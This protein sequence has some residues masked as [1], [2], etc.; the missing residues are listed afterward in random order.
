MSIV[1]LVRV[2]LCGLLEEKDA[3][4]RELQDLGVAHLLGAAD[5]AE[6]G[7]TAPVT[8]SSAREALHYLL[9]A[10]NR[11][12]QAHD[13]K[14]FDARA[15]EERALAIKRQIRALEDER[16]RLERRIRDLAPWGDFGLLDRATV[17]QRLWFYVVPHG[18]LPRIPA[19]LVWQAVHR[20]EQ[21]CYVVVVAPEEPTGMPVPRTHTGSRRLSELR[22][23]LENLQLEI[24]GLQAE[25][26]REARWCDLL[27]ASLDHLEDEA[28]LMRAR[29][30]AADDAPLFVLDAWV[31][32][33]ALP[34][35]QQL[36]MR[37]SAAMLA[38]RPARDDEPPTRLANEGLDAA[39][40]DLLSFFLVPNYSSWDPSRSVFWFFC[41]FFALMLSDAGYAALLGAALALGWRR[42]GR[43][44]FGL[45]FRGLA[46][47]AVL[48]SLAWGIAVGSYW[49]VSPAPESAPGRLVVFD[50]SDMQG[51]LTLS[52]LVG[53]V[54]IAFASLALAAS[55][56]VWRAR[57]VP[58]GWFIVVAGGCITWLAYDSRLVPAAA[59]GGAALVLAGLSTV[60]V[61][62]SERQGLLNRAVDGLLELTRVVG[63]FSDVMSYMRLFALALAGAALARTFNDLAASVELPAPALGGLVTLLILLLGHALNLGLA[64]AS[65]VVHGLR[66]NLIEYLHWSL[67]GEGHPFRP[68]LRKERLT[69]TNSS[70]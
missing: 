48:L 29:C 58:F 28:E 15:V 57:V 59:P 51:W 55:G 23:R 5:A 36:G 52:L 65:A 8:A 32:E 47:V 50:A 3:T 14:G 19:G 24:D 22:R 35:L 70:A 4:L 62:A 40:Q 27:A 38:R 66:L 16:L 54:Q 53:V 20:D 42:L 11:W 9:G 63:L 68:F 41:V 56:T 13:P 25:R 44:P 18:L 33:R 7:S 17:E 46:L 69:W 26:D 64:A 45:R 31:P 43:S 67:R 37:R 49:G 61:F 21:A 60:V 10:A 34:D 6:A 12:H 30:L 2:T 1:P 39:G